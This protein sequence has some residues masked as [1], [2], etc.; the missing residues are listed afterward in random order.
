MSHYLYICHLFVRYQ[1]KCLTIIYLS[2]F[3]YMFIFSNISLFVYVSSIYLN[4]LLFVHVLSNYAHIFV[5]VLSIYLNVLLFVH[6]LSNYAHICSNIPL[7]VHVSSIYSIS[8][9]YYLNLTIFRKM[10]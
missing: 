8:L 7:S 2:N 5:Y 4:V 3:I 10:G 1:F 6:V 9:I